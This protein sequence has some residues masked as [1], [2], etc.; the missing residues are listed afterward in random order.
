MRKHYA[1]RAGGEKIHEYRTD[2][3]EHASARADL[4]GALLFNLNGWIF[5]F[6]DAMRPS[7]AHHE[8]G[9]FE[10]GPEELIYASLKCE[11]QPRMSPHN[12]GW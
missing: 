4:E 6:M 9:S 7:V 11:E 10:I 1:G 8:G 2:R 12:G 3:N 5:Q